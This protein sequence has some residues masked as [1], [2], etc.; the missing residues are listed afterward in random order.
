M[1]SGESWYL[2]SDTWHFCRPRLELRV[3]LPFLRDFDL[4]VDAAYTRILKPDPHAFG[5][6]TDGLGLPADRCVFVDD[7]CETYRAFNIAEGLVLI[8]WTED[9]TTATADGDQ[10]EGPWLTDV[11]RDFNTMR[12]MASWTG[13]MA[14]GR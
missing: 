13:P 4:I 11:I 10:I 9:S 3:K 14:D 7:H 1:T 2:S 6:I 5:F 12:A 8:C